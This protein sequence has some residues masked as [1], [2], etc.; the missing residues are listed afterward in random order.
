MTDRIL[1]TEIAAAPASPRPRRNDS[2][3]H[4]RSFSGLYRNL[5]IGFA[6]ALF[7][8]FFGTAW[9]DWE[10][11]QAVL[12]DLADSKF[13]IFAATFWPQD[14]ILLSALLII[15][16]FGLF[17]ITV[18]AG[19]VWCGYSCPQSTWTWLFMWCEK[20]TEG[21]RNQRIRLAAAPWSLNKLGRRVLKHSLW[22]AIGLLTGLTFVGYFTPIRPLA[23]ELFGLQLG[24]VALFWVLFF[25]AA[26]YI[27][28]GLLREA[29]CLHMCPYA[30]FQS[31]MF[32]K[33]TLAVAY[34]PRRGEARGPRKKGSDARAQGL[35]DCIDCTLCVQ[36]CPTGIDIRDGLQMACIG[37]AACID[38]CDEVMD[39]MGYAR[40]LIGYKSEH[41]LQGGSTHWWRPRL[42][43]YAAALVV[44]LAALV[45]AVQLRP[46]VSLD[47]IK[48]R[49]LFRENAQGQIENIYLLKVI[50]KTERARHYQVRLLDADGFSLQG[51]TAFTVAAGDMS[52]VPV[53]VAL[54]AERPASS[55]QTLSFEISDHDDPGI[56]S[57]AHSRFVAPLN[58]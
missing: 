45:L 17:A 52:E 6:G 35:G 5:R 25:T 7:V 18:F 46:M 42:L 55:S 21:D 41:S 23:A 56:R 38:A 20:V 13:H 54:L 8:L 11:R 19:R 50:N 53:S 2:G 43:G 27:N 24:G 32:D 16:A 37:C 4:T 44:M 47:V 26:T 39:K 48:D 33:D 22:L 57:V 49:G 12:W 40:G 10:G 14:F 9:L 3:I 36:V 29:V 31:V 30:R 58:R 51:K 34:D 28:A 15:C 1:L